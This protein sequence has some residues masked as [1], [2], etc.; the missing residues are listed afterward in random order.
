MRPFINLLP[1]RQ[2]YRQRQLRYWRLLAAGCA[3]SVALAASAGPALLAWQQDRQRIQADYLSQLRALLQRK[4]QQAQLLAKRQKL[5]KAREAQRLS[6]REWEQRL[7]RLASLMPASVWLT[8]LSVKNGQAVIHGKAEKPEDVRLMEQNLRQLPGIVAVAA[9][10]IQRNA[11][12]SLA[13]TFTFVA[14]EVGHAD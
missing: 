13:F 4:H 11:S 6:V 8:S 9:E 7:T 12:S 14:A 1:W 10:G 5:Q 3:L 2:Q